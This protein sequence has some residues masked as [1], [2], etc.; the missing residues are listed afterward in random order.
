MRRPLVFFS[1]GILAPPEF[2]EEDFPLRQTQALLMTLDELEAWVDEAK[3]RFGKVD[4]PPKRRGSHPRPRLSVHREWLD[5]VENCVMDM[6]E[7][8]NDDDGN[9]DLLTCRLSADDNLTEMLETVLD[10]CPSGDDVLDEES[11][12]ALVEILSSLSSFWIDHIACLLKRLL[13][14][15][16][17]DGEVLA[18][19]KRQEILA[20]LSF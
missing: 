19:H 8:I 13:A 18:I 4:L 2:F 10:Q 16:T 20:K 7:A 1:D 9:E 14:Q 6:R 5:M 12:L 17:G 3:R 15:V 11:N